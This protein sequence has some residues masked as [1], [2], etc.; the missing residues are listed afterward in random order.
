MPPKSA[1]PKPAAVL[2]GEADVLANVLSDL[3]DHDAKLVYADWLEEHDDPRGPLLRN[4]VTAHRAGKKLPAL[5][6]APQS[7]CDLVGLT[8][9]EKAQEWLAPHTDTFL[10]L[11]RPA[12]RLEMIP[13]P[14][15][16]LP[17]GGS[18]LAGLPDMPANAEWPECERGTLDFMAQINLADV[19][20]SVV[21]RELPREGI[22]SFFVEESAI[23]RTDRGGWRV[24]HFADATALVRRPR[25][26]SLQEWVHF[27]P[28]CFL[29]TETLT[30]P[31]RNNSPWDDELSLSEDDAEAYWEL[32]GHSCGPRLLGY[33]QPIQNDVLTGKDDRH[34]LTVAP[35]NVFYFTIKEE[36]LRQHRFDRTGFEM[37]R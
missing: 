33:P 32:Y 28:H 27:S 30:L 36:D 19:A 20:S 13:N 4:F 34:L 17:I 25:P 16:G 12:L 14:D 6:S 29:F 7:W 26:A 2:P 21:C 31:C 1:F 9:I 11:A 18:K 22:L 5:K 35:G 8:L 24:F 3:S 15:E 23:D 10:R 37:Q